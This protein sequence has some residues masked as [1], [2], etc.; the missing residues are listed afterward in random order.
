[1]PPEPPISADLS[2]RLASVEDRIRRAA[3]GCG[4]ERAE[5]TLVAVTKKFS[6]QIIREAYAVGLRDFGENYVQEFAAKQPELNG[7][8]GARF[9]LIGHLQSNKAR[10]AA[11][12]FHT[13]E[14]IDSVKLLQRL[15]TVAAEQ[16]VAREALIEVKLSMEASKTG[17]PEA[18]LTELAAAA[19]ACRALSVT[20]LMTVP[21]WSVNPEESRPYFRRLRELARRFEFFKLSMGMSGDFEVA[22]EEGATSIRVGTAL[23][24]PRPKPAKND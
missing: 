7:L 16:K 13:I 17:A 6:A 3:A 4:R 20:G 14:T 1:M 8:P 19:H 23:F 12:L 18:E 24:G 22:I 21:P 10:L 5:I 15:D 2:V 11:D 9:H